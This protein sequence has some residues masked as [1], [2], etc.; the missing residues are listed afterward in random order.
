MRSTNGVTLVIPSEYLL[1]VPDSIS[2]GQRAEDFQQ[3]QPSGEHWK[4]VPQIV[5][6]PLSDDGDKGPV[7][8]K[9]GEEVVDAI[10]VIKNLGWSQ[11]TRDVEDDPGQ[12]QEWHESHGDEAC[13]DVQHVEVDH[14]EDPSERPECKEHLCIDM[15]TAT[16]RKGPASGAQ[17]RED[18]PDGTPKETGD[19][20]RAE[21]ICSV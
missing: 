14:A 20:V 5:V 18:R 6:T 21:V 11:R 9:A 13:D 17:T 15:V 10:P 1:R 2:C 8:V 3:Y 4:S 12:E 7:P 19:H 16:Q